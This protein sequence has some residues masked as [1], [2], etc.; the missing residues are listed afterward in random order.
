MILSSGS[1]SDRLEDLWADRWCAGFLTLQKAGRPAESTQEQSQHDPGTLIY[2]ISP[3]TPQVLPGKVGQH[4][5]KLSARCRWTPGR[6][7]QHK[8]RI[9]LLVFSLQFTAAPQCCFPMLAKAPRLFSDVTTG[10]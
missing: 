6:A 5:R 3:F 7:A 10:R 2:E 8:A 9:V 4:D 1:G